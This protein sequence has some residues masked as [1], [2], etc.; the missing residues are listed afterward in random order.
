MQQKGRRGAAP[1]GVAVGDIALFLIQLL[2][3]FA[4]Q[5]QGQVGGVGEV[6]FFKLLGQAHI[7]PL[8]PL[9]AERFRQIVVHL[10]AQW[11]LDEIDEILFHQAHHNAVTQHGDVGVALGAGD[12]GL[13]TK[14]VALGQ[15]RQLVAAP[16]AADARHLTASL[17]DHIVEIALI[18]LADNGLALV[19]MHRLH[20][21]NHLL[22][23]V[24]GQLLKQGQLQHA[25]DPVITLLALETDLTTGGLLPGE[26]H[27]Q[28]SVVEAQNAHR[29]TA[30]RRGA[31][32]MARGELITGREA[33]AL[34]GLLHL[35]LGEDVHLALEQE[36]GVA[37][38]IP[39]VEQARVGGVLA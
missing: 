30:H 2:L 35:A 12:Q 26:Q 36:N 6:G 29:C 8:G 11:A 5:R 33:A 37:V 39:L 25:R 38:L 32:R 15:F 20:A 18:P 27:I 19:H 4:Q 1:P 16:V 7:Q 17:A 28:E 10:V 31:A 14:T 24:R 9:A 23:I 21:L 3:V 13:F 22:Q 34:N